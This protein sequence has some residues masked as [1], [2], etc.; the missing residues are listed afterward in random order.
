MNLLLK[1]AT[2][3]T[4]L[5]ISIL[6]AGCVSY[7]GSGHQSKLRPQVMGTRRGVESI[8]PTQPSPMPTLQAQTTPPILLAPD[9]PG[10]GLVQT[11]QMPKLNAISEMPAPNVIPALPISAQIEPKASSSSSKKETVAAE[12]VQAKPATSE[13]SFSAD[14]STGAADRESLSAEWLHQY[15]IEAGDSLDIKFR[16]T[17][18]LNDLVTVRP[19]GM[20]SMQIIGDVQAAGLTPEQLRHNLV[21][22]HSKT[23]KDPDV[24]VIVR[25]FSGNSIFVG[26]EV[27]SPGRVPLTGRVTTLRAI[28]LAGG[29]KDTADKRRVIVRHEDGTC[30]TYDLKSVIECTAP[31]QDIQLRPYDVVYVPKSCIAKVNLF[32]EQYIDKVLPF[33][34]SYGVFVTPNTGLSAANNNP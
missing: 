24:A 29:F 18:E 3:F 6:A 31:G 11:A 1:F 7:S 16:V 27:V 30:C 33:S 21:A 9:P 8:S 26:G 2:K 5:T 22:A 32:V 28:I 4:V 25:T 15:I 14:T 20:I 13:T 10:A 17:N 12:D 34:R 19:D 23:L